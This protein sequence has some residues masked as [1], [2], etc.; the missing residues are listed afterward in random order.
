MP[1]LPDIELLKREILKKACGQTICIVR[2]LEPKLVKTENFRK[3]VEGRKIQDAERHGKYLFLKLGSSEYLVL[4]FGLTG[5]LSIQP[6]TDKKLPPSS[7]LVL[8]TEKLLL[9]YYARQLFGL[10]ECCESIEG[11][12]K[13]KELGPD[14]A[15]VSEK[16]FS[17]IFHRGSGAV[18]PALMDQHKLAG[19]G[20]VYADEILFQARLHPKTPLKNLTEA[21]LKKVH[22]QIRRVFDWAYKVEGDRSEMPKES[23][24][25]NRKTSQK[26]PRCG[27]KVQEIAVGGRETFFC[28]ACQKLPVKAETP[29]LL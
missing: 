11:Y 20:N 17:E 10:A 26:C 25:R 18:K 22:A 6:V 7:L 8:E 12:L 23:L 9:V 27:G 4:H 28:T 21:D 3:K 14:A 5:E 13:E 2:V 29:S 24:M 16:K 19:I 15:S 1:E